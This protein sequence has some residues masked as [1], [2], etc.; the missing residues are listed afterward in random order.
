MPEAL[1]R[2]TVEAAYPALEAFAQRL[3]QTPSLSGQ[4]EEVARLVY[5]EM[6]ALGYDEVWV[7][8]VGNVWGKIAGGD[9]APLLF[10]THMDIVDSGD[11]ACWSRPPFGGEIADGFL[12]GRGSCDAKGCL[13]AQVYALGLLRRAGLRPAGDVY[14]SAVVWEE[15]GGLGTAHLLQTFRPAVAV[16]GEPSG[17]TLRRGH[18]GRTEFVLTFRGRSAHASAPERGIN[19]HYS[20]ARFLLALRQVPSRPDPT[21]G[22]NSVAPTLIYAEPNSSNVIPERVTVH[23]DWR[24][25]PGET[26]QDAEAVLA[27]LLRHTLEPGVQASVAVRRRD[28]R[29]YTGLE[30]TMEYAMP[31]Y[32]LAAADPLVLR[33]R[34]LLEEALGHT[35]EVGVWTFSTDGGQISTAGAPCLGFGPGE[36]AL[37][38]VV[39]ERLALA[40]LHEAVMGYMALAMGLGQS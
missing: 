9:G 21:F 31:G 29:T 14:L 19:P 12:W 36:E 22:S 33:A 10:N 28:V 40:Q 1:W 18:R 3:V 17:N 39:D 6:R 8:S 23:L 11:V 38:H 34:Q 25:I 20:V 26:R 13:A 37:A 35:V 27:D 5:A 32:C 24:T 4:E 7:D 30:R 2:S 15:T 16:I